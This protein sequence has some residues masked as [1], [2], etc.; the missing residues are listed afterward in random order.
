MLPASPSLQT[1]KPAPIQEEVVGAA[2]VSQPI[3]A[4]GGVLASQE[5]MTVS[6]A[7]VSTAVDSSSGEKTSFQVQPRA[8]IA[9]LS[10]VS[11]YDIR[12]HYSAGIGL[13]VGISNHVTFDAGFQFSEY[14]VAMNSSNPYIANYQAWAATQGYNSTFESV[15]MK[16]NIV[17]AGFKVHVLGSEARLRPFLGGGAAYSKS[18]VNYDSR[19]LAILNQSGLQQLGRD[20]EISSYMGYLSTGLDVRVTSSISVG[21]TFKYY[22]VLSARENQKFNNAAMSNPYGASAYGYVPYGSYYNSLQDTDKQMV[23][24]SLAQSSVYSILGGVT[25]TF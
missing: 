12:P 10:G 22:R 13:G 9:N 11:Y 2:A 20:Y 23:G 15:A 1:T 8:G 18:F 7:S 21:A 14:G 24:G 6:Q 16:Q 19:I 4:S 25:F 5:V 17:D 3:V